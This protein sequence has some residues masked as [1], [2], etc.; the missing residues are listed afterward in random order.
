M[1]QS[2][3]T[4]KWINNNV[5]YIDGRAKDIPKLFSQAEDKRINPKEEEE[6]KKTLTYYEINEKDVDE[7]FGTTTAISSEPVDITEETEEEEE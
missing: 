2:S 7:Y 3:V 4:Y 1:D 6:N 5:L